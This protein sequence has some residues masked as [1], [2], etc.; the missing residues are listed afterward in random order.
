[1]T[2][3]IE[4]TEHFKQEILAYNGIAMVD[5]R[6][7]RCWPCRML[8]P[9]VDQLAEEMPQYKIAK[10]NVEEQQELAATFQISSIPVIFFLKNG[11]VV[12]KIVGVNPP[13]VYKEKLLALS[14]AK[15]EEQK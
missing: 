1:M 3:H 12:D 5:F 6:A 8:G 14:E 2:L 9:I 11:V 4:S 7:S 10:V 15:E 13:T